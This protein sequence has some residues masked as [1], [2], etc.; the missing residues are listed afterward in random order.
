MPA[1]SVSPNDRFRRALGMVFAV[2]GLVW[3]CLALYNA[4]GDGRF[5]WSGLVPFLV[6]IAGMS[7]A[8]SGRPRG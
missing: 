2:A 1:G 8:R 6:L 3:L 7:L 5:N 4:R